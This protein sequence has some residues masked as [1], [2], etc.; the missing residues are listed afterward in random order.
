MGIVYRARDPHID[1]IVAIKTGEIFQSVLRQTRVV[2]TVLFC[3]TF[4]R[5]GPVPDYFQS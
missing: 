3:V 2:F 5:L 1:R 4:E